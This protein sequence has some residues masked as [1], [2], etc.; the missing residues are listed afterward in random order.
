MERPEREKF[1]WE[2]KKR[3]KIV[4]RVLANQPS[5]APELAR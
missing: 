1:W 4:T 5:A 2:N 3:R